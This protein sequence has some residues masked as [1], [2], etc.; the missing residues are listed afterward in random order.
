M[1]EI[2]QIRHE[3]DTVIKEYQAKIL[4]LTAELE[5]QKNA[6]RTLS[7]TCKINDQKFK[8]LEKKYQRWSQ[9]FLFFFMP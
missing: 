6:N 5:K 9:V 1:L 3:Y 4:L 8:L 2:F 7:D